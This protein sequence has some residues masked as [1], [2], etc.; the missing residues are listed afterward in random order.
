MTAPRNHH[1]ED[2]RLLARVTGRLDPAAADAVDDHVAACAECR[3]RVAEVE[4]VCAHLPA[5][6]VEPS[7]TFDARLR[8]RIDDLDEAAVPWWRRAF[9]W[10]LLP[11]AA[12]VTCVVLLVVGA[13]TREPPAVLEVSAAPELLADLEL[14]EELDAVELVD[15]VDDLDAIRSLPEEEG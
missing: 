6:E 9:A 7:P 4:A 13:P 8:A 3:R 5:F 15:V 11:A 10:A 14:L 2:D 12:T 1:V